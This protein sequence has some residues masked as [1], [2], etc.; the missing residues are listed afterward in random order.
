[1]SEIT[2]L[3]AQQLSVMPDEEVDAS[4]GG[5]IFHGILGQKED[6]LAVPLM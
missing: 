6:V 5:V 2:A 3:E 1:M 4:A